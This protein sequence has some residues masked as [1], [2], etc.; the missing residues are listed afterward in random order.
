VAASAEE[1]TG[2]MP[3]LIGVPYGADMRMFVEVGETPTVMYGPGDVRVAH[4]ADEHVSLDEVETCARVLA[5]WL[6][7][8]LT[9]A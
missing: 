1:V 3:G 8:E 6:L 5:H 7:S 9:P 2:V 4:A